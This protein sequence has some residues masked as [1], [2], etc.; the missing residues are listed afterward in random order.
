[1]AKTCSGDAAHDADA[2]V[3][4]HFTPAVILLRGDVRAGLFVQP[5]RR[6]THR[7]GDVSSLVEDNAVWHEGGIDV[8]G[9]LLASY[10]SAIAAPPTMNTSATTPRRTRAVAQRGEG[11]LKLGAAEQPVGG[12][13]ASRSRAER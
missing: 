4:E 8:T 11:P 5:P 9:N 7:L 13:A 10:A 12:H 1:M 3:V 6:Q 2:G